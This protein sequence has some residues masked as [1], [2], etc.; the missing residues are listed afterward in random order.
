MKKTVKSA[1]IASDLTQKGSSKSHK[2]LTSWREKGIIQKAGL[3]A[4]QREKSF[5]ERGDIP[6]FMLVI[7]A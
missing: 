4:I 5:A 2:K 1:K 6:P 7:Q 3:K